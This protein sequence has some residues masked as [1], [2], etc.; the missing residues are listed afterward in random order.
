V[1]TLANCIVWGNWAPTDPSIHNDSSLAEVAHSDIQGGYGGP[2]NKNLDPLFVSPPPDTGPWDA[3]TWDAT[4]M[5]TELHDAGANWT[6]D[7]LEGLFV[8]P[9]DTDPRWF[10]I[11]A[12]TA[13][14]I[15][16]WGNVTDFV[17]DEDTYALH[18]LHLGSSSPCIDA[19]YGCSTSGGC[20]IPPLVPETPTTDI[21]GNARFDAGMSS[22]NDG[23]GIPSYVDLGAYEYVE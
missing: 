12:N 3:V 5:Q 21:E 20:D 10:L 7:A 19:G 9:D 14:T 4:A 13:D 23:T 2:G 1:P 8:Q 6:P 22:T 18:D 16:V 17:S 11:V 15:R